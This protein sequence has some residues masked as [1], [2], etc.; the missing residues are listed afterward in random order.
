MSE[1]NAII[2]VCLRNLSSSTSAHITHSYL[3]FDVDT[4]EHESHVPSDAGK[5]R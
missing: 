4:T 1:I 3:F 5:R 2:Q